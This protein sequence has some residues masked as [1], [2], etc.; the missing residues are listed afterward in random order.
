VGTPIPDSPWPYVPAPPGT[1]GPGG[2]RIHLGNPSPS[3]TT[4]VDGT[5]SFLDQ[6]GVLRP[7]VNITVQAWDQ[8]GFPDSD[9]LLA[10]TG[11][12][13]NGAYSMCFSNA[14][15][16]TFGSGTADLFLR[17][18]AENTRW[19]VRS[20]TFPNPTYQWRTDTTQDVGPGTIHFGG[21]QP[22]LAWQNRA[23]HAFDEIN[24]AWN[25]LP[26]IG[27]VHCWDEISTCDQKEI[28][29]DPGSSG[30]FTDLGGTVHIQPA[31]PDFPPAAIHELGHAIMK[32]VDGGYPPGSGG[33]HNLNDAINPGMAWSEGW[34]EAF[35]MHV[36]QSDGIGA[37]GAMEATRDS[38]TWG[39]PPTWSNCAALISNPKLCTQEAT[40]DTVESRVA[41]ALEDIEDS[42][43][44]APWDRTGEGFA[45]V[46]STFQHHTD[47]SFADFWSDRTGDGFDVSESALSTLYENTIDYGFVDTLARSAPAAR[48]TP[49]NQAPIPA[50]S[51]N[52]HRFS[53]LG[54][55][56]TW[57]AVAIRPPAGAAYRLGLFTDETFSSPIL[58]TPDVP[59]ATVPFIAYDNSLGNPGQPSCF[60]TK[61]YPQVSQSTGVG[62]YTIEWAQDGAVLPVP[63]T[64]NFTLGTGDIVDVRTVQ[65]TAGQ[66]LHVSLFVPLAS[67]PVL[68]IMQRS[69][70]T[71]CAYLDTQAA[72]RSDNAIGVNENLTFVA[73]A[74]ATYGIVTTPK[75]GHGGFQLH[76][77]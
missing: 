57:Q 58:Q 27:G 16:G 12:D 30:T 59:G 68:S 15:T 8:N 34:A 4:C 42:A 52:T 73:P 17:F 33:F 51:S 2:A 46:W 48:P 25:A 67:D 19:N 66:M 23:L 56:Q 60:R 69:V 26:D 36:L 20:D 43:N 76:V 47:N 5:F 74:T 63:G 10:F 21:L 28:N 41:W 1:G 11:T 77:S 38:A 64:V 40:G 62:Q 65:L 31:D 50:G 29:W 9:G 61:Q 72:M 37:N 35:E 39:D 3:G 54:N 32:D 70:P 55:G 71:T 44:E 13:G 49:P 53:Y 14:E 75:T 18:R 45:N 7:A 22:A 6:N 24:D